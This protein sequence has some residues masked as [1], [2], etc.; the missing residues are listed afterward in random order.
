MFKMK[1]NAYIIRYK[2]TSLVSLKQGN[3]KKSRKLIK[4][5]E[6]R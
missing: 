1:K 6:N 2:L 4:F 5:D 3:V